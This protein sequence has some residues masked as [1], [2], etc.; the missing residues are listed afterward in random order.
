MPGKIVLDTS[1]LIDHFRKSNR[2]DSFLSELI[3]EY[4]ELLIPAIAQFEV[5]V[6]SNEGQHDFWDKLFS[7]VTILPFTKVDAVES[8][9]IN[10]F[11]KK[12]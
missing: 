5:L 12:K 1:V 10:S 11:L 8:A 4:D 7:A 3:E 6:G 9:R 2:E